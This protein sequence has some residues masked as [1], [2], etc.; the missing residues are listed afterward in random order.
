MKGEEASADRQQNLFATSPVMNL[1]R[2]ASKI[3]IYY[4]GY[5]MARAIALK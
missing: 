4:I 2:K 3:K 5:L 1:E